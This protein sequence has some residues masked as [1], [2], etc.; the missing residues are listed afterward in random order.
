[1]AI[2]GLDRKRSPTGVLGSCSQS[3]LNSGAGCTTRTGY[4]ELGPHG[5]HIPRGEPIHPLILAPAAA[6]SPGSDWTHLGPRR[7][8]SGRTKR[9]PGS[10]GLLALQAD[11]RLLVLSGDSALRREKVPGARHSLELMLATVIE[12]D[13]RPR[14]QVGDCS[15]N[16]N[17]GWLC[18]VAYPGR[19][20]H[21][22]ARDIF[23]TL[24]D[25]SDVNST[26]YGNVDLGDTIGYSLGTEDGS[27]RSVERGE[28]AVT[29]RLHKPSAEP[30]DLTFREEVVAI[31]PIPPRLVSEA[32]YS[33]GGLNDVGEQDRGEAPLSSRRMPGP[34]EELLD[35]AHR[36]RVVGPGEVIGR[37]EFGES[38]VGD[39]S[40]QISA[41]ID[42]HKVVANRVE[43]QG[44]G[45]Y[46]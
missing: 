16:Q 40:P 15:G 46:L 17:L 42:S 39:V 35:L 31:E 25:F 38:G 34:S 43:D 14:H 5:S 8:D 2:R 19:R 20:M 18:G 11:H 3:G 22:D 37:G 44:R 32:S 27:R 21:G 13:S 9:P 26:A 7:S 1:M 6:R 10:L 28:H 12:L 24:L 23:A 36:A 33:L 45:L 29:C 30:R 4:V 41:V